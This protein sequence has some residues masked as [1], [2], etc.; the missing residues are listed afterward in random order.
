MNSKFPAI[1]K[2][3][4]YPAPQYW[5]PTVYPVLV[6]QGMRPFV[7]RP[8]DKIPHK[9]PGRLPNKIQNNYPLGGP[10]DPSLRT[11]LNS[12]GQ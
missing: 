10:M 7:H 4:T 3:S 12:C 5:S 6:F 8:L 9:N 2:A 11:P 1:R